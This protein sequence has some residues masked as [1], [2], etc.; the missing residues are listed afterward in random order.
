MI[1]SS[2]SWSAL[3]DDSRSDCTAGFSQE[4]KEA[5]QRLIW[6]FFANEVVTLAEWSA[7]LEM[8]SAETA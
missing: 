8:S 1:V 7:S 6:P 4:G 2:S 5:S 3:I